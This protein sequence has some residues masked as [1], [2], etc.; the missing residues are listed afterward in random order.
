MKSPAL[1]GEEF[2]ER[3]RKNLVILE[4]IRRSGPLS[5][6]DISRLAGLNVVTVTN[7]IEELL[8]S[9]L[10]CEKEFDVS[11]GGR[12][13]VLLDLNAD[14]G[15]TIGVGLN[16]LD[17]VGVITDLDG[18]IIARVKENRPNARAKEIVDCVLKIIRELIKQSES[19]K[20]K[21]KGI[22]IGIAGIVDSKSGTIRWPERIDDKG[23]IYASIYIPL[24]DIIEKEFNLPCLI[25][26]DATVACFAEHWLSLEPQIENILYMFSG[27]GVGLML[28]GYIYRGS[29]GCAGEPAIY[30]TKEDN[31]FN[32]NFGS[33]CFMKRWEIDLG[34]L[35]NVRQGLSKDNQTRHSRILEL[36]SNDI[37]K[38][39]LRDIFQAAKENDSLAVESIRL[40]GKRLGVKIAF[41]VNLLNPQ[42]VV[43]G[44]GIEEAG[45]VLLDTIKD[46]VS[47]WAFEEMSRSVKIIP[48]RLGE[49]SI[50]LGA[51]S[52]VVR[53]IFAQL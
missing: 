7:Y 23:C 20:S 25:E 9:S 24:K 12:R 6:T 30:N 41:L 46:T 5:K 27:V 34:I 32:C 18:K 52:L 19:E 51:A 44:G 3:S 13:P 47:C 1:M 8:R 35:S 48:S 26:N 39:N 42:V 43:V 11:T 40:A 50:A 22:G 10:I 16:L 29:C 15:L 21:I 28:N 31:L 36:A 53:Q 17:M 49:N 45:S 4:T 37:N 38:I 14:A 2:S 33:P